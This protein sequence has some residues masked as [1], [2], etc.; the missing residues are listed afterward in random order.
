M[1]L[2]RRSGP[3]ILPSF[4]QARKPLGGFTFRHGPAHRQR[5]GDQH[6]FL[7]FGGLLAARGLGLA[8]DEAV[9][10]RE[11]LQAGKRGIMPDGP[12]SGLLFGLGGPDLGVDED[13]KQARRLMPEGVRITA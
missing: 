8:V 6:L 11:L 4:D 12:R 3:L 10:G 13:A 5:H 2:K 1:A 7:I 9:K